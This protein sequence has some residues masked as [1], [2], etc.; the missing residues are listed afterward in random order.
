[1]PLKERDL[2]DIRNFNFLACTFAQ[3]KYQGREIDIS[4]I[5]SALPAKQSALFSKLY[6]HYV[7]Q[8]ESQGENAN[9]F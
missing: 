5:T 6:A 7:S 3:M 2:M 9:V 1:M 4:I 8:F